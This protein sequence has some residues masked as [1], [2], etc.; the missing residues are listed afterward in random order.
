MH[1][2]VVAIC[3]TFGILAILGTGYW[4]LIALAFG[5]F[6]RDG[7]PILIL[8]LAGPLSLLPAGI[9]GRRRPFPAGAW[10][11]AGAVFCFFWHLGALMGD[12]FAQLFRS[13]EAYL[14]VTLIC[15]PMLLTGAG[16]LWVSR[17]VPRD[18]IRGW[19]QSPT[20]RR[21]LTIVGAT[22]GAAGA[23]GLVAWFLMQPVWV[24]TVTPEGH[25]PKSIR[26]D[27]RS[28][29]KCDTY[30]KRQRLEAEVRAVFSDLFRKSL[31]PEPTTLGI[32]VF[33]GS[34]EGGTSTW[35]LERN[36]K[37]L[38]RVL[39]N[40]IPIDRN[41]MYLEPTLDCAAS[42]AARQILDQAFREHPPKGY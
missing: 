23:A 34:R 30:E 33:T 20:F 19:W 35:T 11:T 22:L 26:F 32:S 12:G 29:W 37:G 17:A 13:F 6:Q 31:S 21:R 15:L 8:L 38:Y 14:P 42:G 39:Q 28:P 7:V 36:A 2:A 18:V 16:F 41:W 9:V 25:P 3:I 5:A 24:I 40:N 4:C 27:P 1:K 10:L